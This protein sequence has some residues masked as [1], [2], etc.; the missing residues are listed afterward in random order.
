MHDLLQEMGRQIV[1]RQS[2]QEPGN[3]SRLWEEADVC[4]VLSQNTVSD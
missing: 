2:P 1:R 4:H 3:R